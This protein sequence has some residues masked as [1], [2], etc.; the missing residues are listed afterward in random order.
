MKEEAR[1]AWHGAGAE[2]RFDPSD[3]EVI[4]LVLGQIPELRICAMA[5]K[6]ARATKLKF[7]LSSA[8]DL[9][10]LL[11]SRRFT[12]GGHEFGTK[13]IK[14]YLPAEFFPIHDEGELVSRL[15][16]ALLRCRHEENGKL[17][18]SRDVLVAQHTVTTGRA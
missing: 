5:L 16:I 7:P 6:R 10:G 4:D 12:G 8:K 17:N 18:A 14:T 1:T 13:D 3:F 9:F 15:Y 11:E 2:L